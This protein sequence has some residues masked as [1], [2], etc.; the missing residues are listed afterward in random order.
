MKKLTTLFFATLTAFAGVTLLYSQGINSQGGIPGSNP[1]YNQ[2]NLANP[3]SSFNQGNYSTGMNSQYQTQNPS[4]MY[5]S[6]T[7][8][9]GQTPNSNIYSQPSNVP[10]NLNYNARNNN[11]LTMKDE[12]IAQK[13]RWAIRDDKNLSSL[14][15]STEVIVKNYNVTLNG[16]V[17][18]ED[19]KSKIASIVHQ[20]TGVKGI[21]NNLTLGSR[22]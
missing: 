10:N 1:S 18:Y 13:I 4:Q 11:L 19:E 16:H 14:A 12:E 9:Y 21:S 3:N 2:G 17:K 15:K 6:N 5:N 22:R 8:M 7:G 20:V